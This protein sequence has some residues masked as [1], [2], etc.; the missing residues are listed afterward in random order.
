MTFGSLLFN[1]APPP[2][3]KIKIVDWNLLWIIE[4]YW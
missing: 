1:L 3:K 2:Q 4:E